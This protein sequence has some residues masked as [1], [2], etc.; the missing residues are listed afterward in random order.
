MKLSNVHAL[1][2]AVCVLFGGCGYVGYELIELPPDSGL[3]G[4]SSGDGG[5]GDAQVPGSCQLGTVQHCGACD[6]PCDT[7]GAFQTGALECVGGLC[8]VG[9][10]ELG[11]ADCNGNVV[12]GCETDLSSVRNCGACG[13]ACVGEQA[14]MACNAGVCQV[15]G[16]EP[17]FDDCDGI[18]STGCERSLSTLTDCGSCGAVCAADNGAGACSAEGVCGLAACRAGYENCDGQ[19]LVSGCETATTTLTD[20]GGCG[21]ACSVPFGTASCAGGRCSAAT[22]TPPFADCDGNDSDCETSI[23][24]LTDCGACGAG[25]GVGGRLDNG[26]ATCVT[27]TCEVAQ[28]DALFDNCDNSAANG[29][30]RSLNTTSDCGACG[31]ACPGIQTCDGGACVGFA[32]PPSNVGG[33]SLNRVGSPTTRFDCG[34]TVFDSTTLA[35]S[36]ACGVPLPT[37]QVVDQSGGQSLVALVFQELHIEAGSALQLTGDKPV[38]IVAFGDITVAGQILAD[39]NGRT[40]GSG[41]NQ[42]C[43]TS[44]G[45]NGGGSSSS[46]AGGGGGAGFGTNGARGGDG[47]ASA[48]PGNGGSSRGFAVQSP[49]VAGCS[50]GTGGGCF[51]N[52]GA[53][54][55]AVQVSS[56]TQLLVTGS[57]SALGGSGS[58]GCGTEGGGGGGG[59]GGGILLEARDLILS[60]TLLANGGNG[61]NGRGGG[62]GGS[63]GTGSRGPRVGGDGGANGGGG[64]GG[65]V[66]RIRLSGSESCTLSG[67]VSPSASQACP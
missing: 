65:A 17:G 43:G 30:E 34:T 46:G 42:S 45:R 60:G 37:G 29:C 48:T 51:S 26:S 31:A 56:A 38:A 23:A 15:A 41:G 57:I 16:C 52:S 8:V 58:L 50:G 13:V 4:G 59:S 54:A 25:C 7:E 10:C 63:G 19:P 66:G 40:P 55:G 11:F 32:I 22:C 5:A 12:D 1:W 35:F 49:L 44:A 47:G 33:A 20:C 64:G 53:G 14:M 18:V 3:G 9:R 62:S 6:S 24:T 2:C 67:V 27:G 39:A 61:G 21:V 36:N 28:C